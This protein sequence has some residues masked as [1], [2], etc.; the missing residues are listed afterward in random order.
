MLS[1]KWVVKCL[2]DELDIKKQITLFLNFLERPDLTCCQ[3]VL[4]FFRNQPWFCYNLGLIKTL[5]LSQWCTWNKETL[6]TFYL[7]SDC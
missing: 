2:H 4:T 1:D 6:L 3:Q 7:L 5:V